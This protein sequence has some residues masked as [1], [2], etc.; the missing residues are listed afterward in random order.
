MFMAVMFG[1]VLASDPI[2]DGIL[3]YLL[4]LGLISSTAFV[5]LAS[6]GS[7][8]LIEKDWMVSL[9]PESIHLFLCFVFFVF[10][11]FFSHCVT[12]RLQLQTKT[13]AG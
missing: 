5:S 9:P 3:F 4:V 7:T 2:E 12:I 11:F 8:L 6:S 10:V 1:G 13:K